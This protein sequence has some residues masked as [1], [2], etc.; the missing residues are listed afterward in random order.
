MATNSDMQRILD[1][2]AAKGEQSYFGEQVS[3]LEHSLQCA[4]FAEQTGAGPTV[5]TAALLHDI[6]HLVHDLPE[7]IA[8]HGQDGLHEQV[9][10]EYLSQWFG[11]AVIA[12]IRLHVAA[13][14]YLCT[15]DA[16]YLSQLSQ[17]SVESLNLQGGPMNKEEMSAFEALPYADQ[18]I[19]L[20]RWDDE[21][22]IPQLS[23]PGL[24]HYLEILVAA[25]GTSA[26]SK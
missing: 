5:L 21:G 22:K 18:A 16:G 7:D 3:I 10:A 9:A 8:E 4:Y 2:M 14:R 20:R 15:A 17:A 13:K 6:G 26:S 24:D 12:P 1:L 11:E 23:V 25:S 19:Q